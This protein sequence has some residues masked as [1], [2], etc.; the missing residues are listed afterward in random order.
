MER[1]R[2]VAWLR[3]VLAAV[4]AAV[5]GVILNLAAWLAVAGVWWP[6]TGAVNW[7]GVGLAAAALMAL[8]GLKWNVV[9]VIAASAAL[10]V[11]WWTVV[12]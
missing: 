3:V 10:G 7:F 8:N 5:V 12:R 1:L 4:T 9:T 6:E 2:Q 11:I